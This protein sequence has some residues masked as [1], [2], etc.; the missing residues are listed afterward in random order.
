MSRNT[1]PNHPPRG[2]LRDPG[3][4]RPEFTAAILEDLAWLGLE[5][6]GAPLVQSGRTPLYAA[7]LE[8]LASRE[9][10]AP[11]VPTDGMDEARSHE[12]E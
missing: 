1:S 3:R 6:D 9:A 10:A 5:P 11:A 2:D 4:C 8:R 12:T 7:A